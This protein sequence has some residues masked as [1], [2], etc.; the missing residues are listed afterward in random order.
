MV[1]SVSGFWKIIF[2]I[3]WICET[4]H[5]TI[6]TKS[7]LSL[8]VRTSEHQINS[9]AHVLAVPFYFHAPNRH[10]REK[11][12]S[13]LLGGLQSGSRSK[14]LPQSLHRWNRWDIMK[15]NIFFAGL[16]AR[17]NWLLQ[18][19]TCKYICGALLTIVYL[20]LVW[21]WFWFSEYEK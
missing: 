11:Q 17:K 2:L 10:K 12:E 15:N 18:L 4:I 19:K 5:Y 8:K 9:N 14:S 6:N 21:Y 7:Q 16:A 13:S 20:W 3:F 1:L